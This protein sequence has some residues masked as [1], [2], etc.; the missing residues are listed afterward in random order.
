M[1]TLRPAII[2]FLLIYP[3]ISNWAYANSAPGDDKTK[4]KYPACYNP[5]I[6]VDGNASDWPSGDLYCNFDAKVFYA[7]TNDTSDL[8]LFVQVLDPSQQM[9]L[10]KNGLTIYIDPQGKKKKECS[11]NLKFRLQRL[12]DKQPDRPGIE[13]HGRLPHDSVPPPQDQ[14]SPG[15]TT[16]RNPSPQ[17]GTNMIGS[18]KP[19]PVS[20]IL[21]TGGFKTGFN[22][23]GSILAGEDE[24]SA[25]AA[26][27]SAN[28]LTIEAKVPLQAFQKNPRLSCNLT[29][30][31][32]TTTEIRN[33]DQGGFEDQPGP[34]PGQQYGERPGSGSIPGGGHSEGG[35]TPG[36][37][38][39][40]EHQG[41]PQ[42]GMD[43]QDQSKT[44]RIWHKFSLAKNK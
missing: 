38:K 4:N 15:Q 26:I 17:N 44:Y 12:G 37:G 20:T 25:A 29:M 9:S 40:M 30:G 42:P 39:R 16:H 43:N 8:F 24:I 10:Y 32:E 23:T 18:R 33:H 22:G 21:T 7:A 27:D 2:F 13:N 14:I 41:G 3:M 19:R 31:F 35:D 34:M 6:N 1:K 11:L 5:G 36:G 28:V